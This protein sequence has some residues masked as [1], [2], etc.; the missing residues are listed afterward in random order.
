[1]PFPRS[2]FNLLHAH[3]F[4]RQLTILWIICMTLAACTE[5]ASSSQ[6]QLPS[7][8]YNPS[9]VILDT[10]H[11]SEWEY[12]P[13]YSDIYETNGERRFSLT[14]TLSVR[15]ISPNDSLFIEHVDYYDSQGILQHAYL[16]QTILLHPLESVEFVVA[17]TEKQ[18]G[19]GA[20]FLVRWGIRKDT[21]SPIIQAVMIG[22]YSQQG[23]SFVTEGVPTTPPQ[24]TH[25]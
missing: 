16:T 22:T 24:Q 18:G 25:P 8:S 12:V 5:E 10:L 13:I 23:I 9:N 15:N 17:D 7:K 1:M 20:N 19:A 4:T 3:L 2:H 6:K 14:A 21:P 11:Q